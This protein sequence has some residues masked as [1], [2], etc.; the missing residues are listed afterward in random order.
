MKQVEFYRSMEAVI[1]PAIERS[2]QSYRD[3][4]F[5]VVSGDGLMGMIESLQ[6]LPPHRAVSFLK[7][8]FSQS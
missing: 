3:V 7:V 5:E 2:E 4:D 1:Q 8:S 6:A